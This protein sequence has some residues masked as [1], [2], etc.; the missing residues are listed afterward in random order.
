MAEDRARSEGERPYFA[1]PTSCSRGVETDASETAFRIMQEEKRKDKDF[2][3]SG[4]ATCRQVLH[5]A[6]N[7]STMVALALC[8]LAVEEAFGR[9]RGNPN[10]LEG[11]V[12]SLQ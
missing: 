12:N 2:F 1:I 10:R 9:A 3:G 5:F 7:Q 11:L 4:R 8:M 6:T